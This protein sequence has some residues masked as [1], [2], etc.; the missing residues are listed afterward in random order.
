MYIVL[1]KTTFGYELKACGFNKD[2]AKYAGINEKR[3][4]VLSM[5]ISGHLQESAQ[6]F[7]TYLVVQNGIHR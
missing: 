1:S 3:N 4:I 2:A 7:I 5:T 6:D